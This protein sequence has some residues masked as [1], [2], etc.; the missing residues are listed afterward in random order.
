MFHE[1]YTDLNSKNKA[2]VDPLN[3]RRCLRLYPHD[4]NQGGFFIALLERVD[5]D[6]Q[7]SASDDP[8]L[9]TK[10]RQKPILDELEEFSAWY[11]K[12][13]KRYCEANSVPE[14]ERE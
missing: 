11:E 2:Q 5:D 12:E 9:N 13:Y 6:A 7:Q 10:I 1:V 4:D 3:L 8:W 14:S